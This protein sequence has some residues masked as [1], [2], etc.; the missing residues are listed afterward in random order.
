MTRKRSRPGVMIGLTGRL[1]GSAPTTEGSM[2]GFKRLLLVLAVLLGAFAAGRATAQDAPD[3]AGMW[4]GAVSLPT[5]NL[6]LVLHVQRGDDGVLSAQIENFDQ[7]PG[8]KAEITE[9][10]TT[11]GQLAFKV[12]PISASYE[13]AWDAA[14]QQWKGTL[15]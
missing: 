15:T 7:N 8:N 4:N 6:T 3:I 11:G 10:T 12:A 9:I 1:I 14:A 2:S 13:G 5:G